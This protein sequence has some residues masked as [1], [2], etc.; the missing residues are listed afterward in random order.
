MKLS[1]QQLQDL[2]IKY[3][4]VQKPAK[5]YPMVQKPKYIDEFY[6]NQL[7]YQNTNISVNDVY[8]NNIIK[9]LFRKQGD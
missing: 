2:S 9:N 3:P 4:T 7:E 1:K 5:K 6:F 8:D